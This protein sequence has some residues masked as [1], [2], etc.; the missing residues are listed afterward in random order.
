MHPLIAKIPCRRLLVQFI[1]FAIASVFAI[2]ALG[3]ETPERDWASDPPKGSRYEIAYS[4]DSSA[5]AAIVSALNAGRNSNTGLYSDSMFIRWSPV[6]DVRYP[7]H[8]AGLEL[9][10]AVLPVF[11]KRNDLAIL[12]I[13]SDTAGYQGESTL[14]FDDVDYFRETYVD[15]P[16]YKSEKTE[17][18]AGV[19]NDRRAQ[20]IF[21]KYEQGFSGFEH[22]K[23]LPAHLAGASSVWQSPNFVGEKQI[24]FARFQQKV[25]LVVRQVYNDIFVVFVARD[26]NNLNDICYLGPAR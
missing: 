21:L 15:S 11:P 4:E 26:Q 1:A 2:H 24:N 16:R 5:C 10:Y 3:Q 19:V 20:K 22:F 17:G 12:K 25:L 6:T 18:L 9:K 14:V 13:R 8:S 23:K 7:F